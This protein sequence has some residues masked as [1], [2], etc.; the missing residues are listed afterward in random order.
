MAIDIHMVLLGDTNDSHWTVMEIL[1]PKEYWLPSLMVPKGIVVVFD[2]GQ[3]MPNF[4]MVRFHFEQT[5]TMLLIDY[6]LLIEA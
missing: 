1:F 2:E 5:F 6:I 4:A 3:K